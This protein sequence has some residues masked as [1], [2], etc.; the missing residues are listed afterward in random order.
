MLLAALAWA[1]E[2]RLGELDVQSL[3]NTAWAF[4]TVSHDYK[5]LFLALA[6]AA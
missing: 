4:A 2:P 3:A 5:A 1:T 6:R